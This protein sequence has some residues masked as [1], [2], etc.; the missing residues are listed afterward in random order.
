MV[1]KVTFRLNGQECTV[2]AKTGDSLN[3][4]IRN[5]LGLTGTKRGCDYGGCGSCTVILDDEAVYSCMIPA[6]RVANRDVLTIEGL[7]SDSQMHPIQEAFV[8]NGALQCG[9]CTPGI[10]L[11]AKTFLEANAEP[12]EEQVRYA[13]SGNICRCTGYVKIIRAVLDA[14]EALRSKGQ[15]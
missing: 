8:R 14:A 6:Q 10:I 2:L 7:G 4:V 12:T 3:K 1:E 11:A 5:Y 15:K 9:F 13:L